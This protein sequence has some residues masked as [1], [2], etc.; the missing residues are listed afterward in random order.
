MKMQ[1]GYISETKNN[2]NQYVYLELA[3]KYWKQQNIQTLSD[4][5]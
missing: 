5:E 2:T 4:R 1:T 3:I